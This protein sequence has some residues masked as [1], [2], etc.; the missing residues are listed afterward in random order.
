MCWAFF[1]MDLSTAPITTYFHGVLNLKEGKIVIFVFPILAGKCD[2]ESKINHE[3]HPRYP[4]TPAILC[5]LSFSY[6]S[7]YRK[8]GGV[9]RSEVSSS[10]ILHLNF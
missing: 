9:Q 10:V 5:C 3:V 2:L 8:V 7:V 6:G 4:L 1:L